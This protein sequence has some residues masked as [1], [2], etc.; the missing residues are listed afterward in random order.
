[1]KK[2]ESSFLKKRSKKLLDIG[3]RLSAYPLY[4]SK[5]FCFFFSKKKSLLFCFLACA[6]TPLD[7]AHRADGT[8]VV[9][10]HFLRTWDPLTVFFKADTGPA[11]GGPED[12]PQRLV[13]MQPPVPGA[14][15]WLGPRVLQFRPAEPWQPLRQERVTVGG[16]TTTLVPLLPAPTLTGPADDPSGIADLDRIALTFPTPVDTQALARLLTVEL[17]PQPGITST[18][19]AT[20]TSQDF[21]IEPVERA[22][23]SDPQTYMVVLHRPVADGQVA[24]LRLRLSDVPGLDAPMFETRLHTSVPFALTDASCGSGFGGS[25]SD[26]L[27]QCTPDDYAAAPQAR[28]LDLSFSARPRALDAVQVRDA[29]RI[30][31]HVDD[32]RAIADGHTLHVTGAFQS[33]TVY[34]LSLSPASLRDTRGRR[35]AVTPPQKFAFIASPPGLRWD[36]SQGIVERFGP[37]MLP[38]RG[39]G[40]A[41]ADLRIHPVDPAARDFWPFPQAGLLTS[42]DTPPP[43]PGHEPAPWDQP[44]P[45]GAPEMAAR[46][47]ALGSPSVSTLVDLPLSPGGLE[48]KFGLDVAPLLGRIAGKGEPGA[49]LLGMRPVDAHER[50]WMRVQ[51]T[52]LSLTTIEE[53]DTVRFVVTSLATAKP[54]AGATVELQQAQFTQFATVARGVT[55]ADGSFTWKVPEAGPEGQRGPLSRIL[56]TK[57][58][59]TLV[60]DPHRGAPEYTAGGWSRGGGNW[61]DWAANGN[62]APRR[63]VPQFLCHIFT[64][65]P[66][67]RPEE[68][69]LIAGMART[70]LAGSLSLAAGSGTVI[71]TGPDNQEWKLP[72]PLDDAGGFHIAFDAHTTATGEYSARF[73]SGDKQGGS[74]EA[75]FQKEAYRLPTFEVLLTGP[76]TVPL[77]RPFTVDL[78]A[79]WFAG[80]LVSDRPVE[81][82]VT[83]FPYVWSPPGREGFAFS[84]DSRFSGDVSFRSTPVLDREV[85]TDA[86]GSAQLVLDP[87][88]EPTAQP[89]EYVAEATVT[90]DDDMQVRSTQHVIAL[91]PFVLGLKLPRYIPH[92]GAID[93]QALALDGQG[94][95]LAGLKISAKLIRRSWNAVLQA[96]DF[97]AGAAKYDTQVI[98]TVVAERALVSAADALKL[99]FDAQAA[100]VYIVELTASDQAGRAQTVRVDCF[101]AGDTPVTWSAPPAQTVTLT[102]DKPA[103]APGETA[104]LLI[105]SPFQTA[106]ALAVIEEPEGPFRY[107]WVEVSHGFGRLAVPIRKPQMPKLAVHVLLMRGRLAGAWPSAAAP[108]DL[109]TGQRAPGAD[110]GSGAASE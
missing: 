66:I 4:I 76:Q 10:D 31:P 48:R 36:A 105:Q 17:R 9:P 22:R 108:F 60:L 102:P 96:S 3:A 93:A 29:L 43:L 104:T 79:R 33:A 86:G 49:Y 63:E 41:Q 98:D 85:K 69:V 103:Y 27:R 28:E 73:E 1:M 40:Y 72:A 109:R 77:D 71:V 91:P 81:W 84:S 54:V 30:T 39:Q 24:I 95:A 32:L 83:Q 23:R 62:L 70:Y 106:R 100:G 89:R 53:R 90:G 38:M 59:D 8:I 16:A 20:L 55:A 45:I 47:N 78:L 35:L 42:D 15:Q 51:V 19:T 57:G 25:L 44:G 58:T 12:A 110:S 92:A 13:G 88:I 97:A 14:W 75:G 46:L 18:A 56:V 2:E 61:M 68:K 21:A 34:T 64:E 7:V 6:A 5:V 87:T 26:G 101:M 99:H 52:D 67:Y 65:R 37:Q 50:H 82:R 80:G 94:H 74:C 107:E 11:A